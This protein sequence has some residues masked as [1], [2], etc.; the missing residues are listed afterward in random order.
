M[1]LSTIRMITTMTTIGS[2]PRRPKESYTSVGISVH[3]NAHDPVGN[4]DVALLFSVW[5]AALYP[6]TCV[7][8]ERESF[9]KTFVIRNM[10]MPTV[11]NSTM[12]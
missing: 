8:S 4:W 11:A 6:S 2:I 12:P 7:Q 10:V 9:P 1:Y 5:P 3:A